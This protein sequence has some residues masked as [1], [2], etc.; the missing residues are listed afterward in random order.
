MRIPVRWSTAVDR[1]VVQGTPASRHATW[2]GSRAE[3]TRDRTAMSPGSTP[4]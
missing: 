3:L 2:T 1:G 4:P